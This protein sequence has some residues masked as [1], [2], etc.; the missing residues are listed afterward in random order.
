M[1][2][3][4]YDFKAFIIFKFSDNLMGKK[5]LYIIYYVKI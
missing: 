2:S 5:Y 1:Y 4:I 3:H